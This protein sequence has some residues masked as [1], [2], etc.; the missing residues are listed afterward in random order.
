MTRPHPCLGLWIAALAAGCGATR[1]GW[2]KGAPSVEEVEKALEE[3]SE[4]RAFLE[5]VLLKA[6]SKDPIAVKRFD[7]TQTAIAVGF[8]ALFVGLIAKAWADAQLRRFLIANGRSPG[9]TLFTCRRCY[10]Q[11]GSEGV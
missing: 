3:A 2:G 9:D 4:P 8:T 7:G 10:F 5:K 11:A 1:S 6:L